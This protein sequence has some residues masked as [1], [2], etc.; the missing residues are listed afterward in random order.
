MYTAAG[1][2]WL[3]VSP[4]SGTIAAGGMQRLVFSVSRTG[5]VPGMRRAIVT[6]A[7]GNGVQ[8]RVLVYVQQAEGKK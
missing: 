4:G 7:D 5:I 1:E 6:L 8:K 2:S 3:R